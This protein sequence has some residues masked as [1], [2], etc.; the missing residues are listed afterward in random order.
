MLLTCV[1]HDG[2]AKLVDVNQ[3]EEAGLT[4]DDVILRQLLIAVRTELERQVRLVRRNDVLRCVR[5]Y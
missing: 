2:E 1:T 3:L 5:Q 4:E